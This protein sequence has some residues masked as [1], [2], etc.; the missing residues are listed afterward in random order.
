[1]PLLQTA[2]LLVFVLPSASF[3]KISKDLSR[4][5]PSLFE[6]SG[7]LANHN[8]L[9]CKVCTVFYFEV[10][11]QLSMLLMTKKIPLNARALR[12]IKKNRFGFIL[13]L[14]RE[15]VTPATKN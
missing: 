6:G 11:L 1:M 8:T 3:I 4:Y 9:T 2:F 13:Y 7:T 10:A 14:E 12:G 5:H 15:K